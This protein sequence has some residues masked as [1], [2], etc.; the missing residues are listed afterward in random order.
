MHGR[1]DSQSLHLARHGHQRFT[2]R[3]YLAHSLEGG[4]Y[5]GGIAFLSVETVLPTMLE[6]LGS[7]TWLIGVAPVL[8]MLGFVLPSML[9]AHLFEYRQRMI[10]FLLISGIFQRLPFLIGALAL[11]FLAEDFPL[12]TL[13]VVAAV[14]FLSGLFGGIGGPAWMELTSKILPPNRRASALAIRMLTAAVIGIAAGEV[15]ER[16][17]ERHPG[18]DGYGILHLCTFG[19]LVLSY[20]FFTLQRESP[21]ER[22]NASR[23]ISLRQNIGSLPAL[24]RANPALKRLMLTIGCALSVW[25]VV[26]F[27][28]IYARQSLELPASFVGRLV[29]AQMIGVVFGNIVGG[30][31]G[32]RFGGRLM[33]QMAL[34]GELLVFLGCNLASTA[35]TFQA[36]FFVWGMA[37]NLHRIS[38]LT[39]AME[40]VPVDRRPTGLAMMG[41]VNIP[42]L[43]LMTT[44]G[45]Q[46]QQ[47]LPGEGVQMLVPTVVA[48]CL[49]L[50]ALWAVFG[51]R[52]ETPMAMK[53]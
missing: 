28:A 48:G 16:V 34:V 44:L 40:V 6:S 50:V 3:N 21:D 47:W 12:L 7:P 38:G 36:L 52:A 42:G 46:L 1:A 51:V 25:I 19:F 4:C 5:M 18:A 27:M 14:P 9:T 49:T 35:F 22:R 17:L 39:L 53:E 15:V 26:P 23:R 8:M 10:P 29:V 43:L 33:M 30:F 32:D 24:L 20:L 13:V 11:F 41:L 31:L 2:M 37:F 45:G